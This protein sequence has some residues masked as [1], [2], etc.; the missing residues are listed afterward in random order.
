MTLLTKSKELV[1]PTT[2]EIKKQELIE[3]LT[4]LVKAYADKKSK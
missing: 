4:K 1:K 2:E 3:T